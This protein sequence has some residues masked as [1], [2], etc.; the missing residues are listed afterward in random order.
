MTKIFKAV[1]GVVNLLPI[2]YIA[3]FFYFTAVNFGREFSEND[4]S[5]HSIS[6]CT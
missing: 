5:F 3:Y 2:V 6:P 4:N 1:L